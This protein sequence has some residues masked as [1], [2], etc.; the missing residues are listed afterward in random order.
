MN[1]LEIILAILLPPLAVGLR[2]GI[3]GVFFLN[4]LLFLLGWLP[5]VIHAFW[6]LS[7]R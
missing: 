4:L 1:I 2:R 6:V 3:S 7:R 5:G